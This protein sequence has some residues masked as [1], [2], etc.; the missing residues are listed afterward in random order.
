MAMF[1]VSLS[2][3]VYRYMAGWT[4]KIQGKTLP[5]MGPNFGYTQLSPVGVCGQITPFNFPFLMATFKVAPVLATG[6]TA[7][8][9]P[10]D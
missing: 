10:A 5:M 7:V 9:K 2:A 1:D 3:K 4:D 8:L 6:C